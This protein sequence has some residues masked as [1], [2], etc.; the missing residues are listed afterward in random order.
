MQCAESTTLRGLAKGEELVG[1]HGVQWHRLSLDTALAL[2]LG[3]SHATDLWAADLGR[4]TAMPG[5]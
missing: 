2:V 1:T 4:R 5:G 3:V